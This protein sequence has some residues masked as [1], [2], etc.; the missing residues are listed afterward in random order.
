M[1]IKQVT[2]FA[3]AQSSREASPLLVALCARRAPAR[4]PPIRAAV[5]LRFLAW[6]L[7]RARA[8][9]RARCTR[10]PLLP[11]ASL[12]PA[13][14][15]AGWL[16]AGALPAAD[17]PISIGCWRSAAGGRLHWSPRSGFALA[18]LALHWQ[19]RVAMGAAAAHKQLQVLWSVVLQVIVEGWKSYKD[20][21]ILEPFS[22][23]V[24][25]IG[26]WVL[27]LA[28]LPCS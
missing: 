21:T 20:Q 9:R 7:E 14:F 13:R 10:L 11:P 6:L 17:L 15:A 26:E 16:C 1:F 12:L 8:S 4:S 5:K 28:W 24:N 27:P 25:V 23:K 18:L 22:P 3:H 2:S 19:W